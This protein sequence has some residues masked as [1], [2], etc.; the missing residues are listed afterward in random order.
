MHTPTNRM[1]VIT[2]RLTLSYYLPP[3]AILVPTNLTREG[4]DCAF[5]AWLSSQNK[6]DNYQ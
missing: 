5:T 6:N 1:Y 2:K 3:S 4:K